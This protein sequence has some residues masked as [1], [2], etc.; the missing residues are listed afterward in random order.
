MRVTQG[1]LNRNLVFWMNRGLEDLGNANEQLSTG[2][3]VNR[4]SD[5]V[6]A[7]GQIMQ[8]GRD[9][10]QYHAHLRNLHSADIM[11]SFA[12]S[13]LENASAV[14]T[15]AKELAIQASSE[16]Y[17]GSDLQTMA[18]EMEGLLGSMVTLANVKYSGSYVFS[19]ESTSTTPYVA[20]V[21]ADGSIE[22]VAYQGQVINTKVAIGSDAA[23]D[24]NLVGKEIFQRDT[25]VFQVLIGLRDAMEANDRGEINRLLDD[26]DVSH[27]DITESLGQLGGRKDQLQ[28]LQA[29]FEQYVAHNDEA[30]SDLQDADIAALSVDYNALMARL[31]MV[32]RVTAESMKPTLA[33]YI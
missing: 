1:T 8:L 19:G 20:T 21:R 2:Q 32:L 13:S 4:F 27:G 26:L 18:A 10:E 9:T 11:L 16:T 24:G 31:Q 29:S 22:S 14:L 5:D 3:R 25:D 33:D 23:A 6:L 28:F 30:I 7:S 17:S 12:T 15:R